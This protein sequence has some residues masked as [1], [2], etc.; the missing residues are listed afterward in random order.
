MLLWANNLTTAPKCSRREASFTFL[1]L[2]CR[3]WFF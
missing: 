3:Y 2:F 1:C